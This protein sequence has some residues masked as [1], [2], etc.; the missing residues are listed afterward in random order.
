MNI[1]LLNEY[2]L[3]V[4]NEYGDIKLLNMYKVIE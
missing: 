4:L 1:E 3:K 2:K